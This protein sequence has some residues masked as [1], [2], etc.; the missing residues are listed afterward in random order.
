MTDNEYW[1]ETSTGTALLNVVLVPSYSSGTVLWN[2]LRSCWWVGCL[3]QNADSLSSLFNWRRDNV[4]IN[5]IC[6]VQSGH[7]SY[8]FTNRNSF[9]T[10]KMLVMTSWCS[11]MAIHFWY[12]TRLEMSSLATPK[13][14]HRRCWR[15]QRF[16]W[17][18]GSSCTVVWRALEWDDLF[19]LWPLFTFWS[20]RPIRD[21]RGM[22]TRSPDW[23]VSIWSHTSFC[24]TL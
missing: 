12:P 13:K 16:V 14:R 5:V 18:E 20:S 17:A 22:C 19:S 8:V 15:R 24:L 11:M 1:L 10:W 2:L 21:L 4:S 6:L 7:L 9:R 3:A 23:G